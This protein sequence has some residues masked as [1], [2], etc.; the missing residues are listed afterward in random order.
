MIAAMI[1]RMLAAA[2]AGLT[3]VVLAVACQQPAPP[4]WE[5]DNPIK[6]LPKAPLGISIDLASDKFTGQVASLFVADKKVVRR[7]LCPPA[8]PGLV[9]VPASTSMLHQ[10]Q[11]ST[12]H[13]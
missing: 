12:S 3:A 5:I 2:A 7:R 13:Q 8:S 4:P 6:P 1:N 10:Q 11:H 9:L